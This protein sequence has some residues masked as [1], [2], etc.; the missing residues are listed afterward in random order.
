M[1]FLNLYLI[2]SFL[3]L[4][5]INITLCETEKKA[6]IRRELTANN[7]HPK[8][9]INFKEPILPTGW[10]EN[11]KEA[12]AKQAAK[13]AGTMG[14]ATRRANGRLLFAAKN[15]DVVKAKLALAD[16]AKPNF[17]D[18]GNYGYTPLGGAAST[19]CL[20]LVELLLNCGANINAQNHACITALMQAAGNNHIEVVRLLLNRGADVNLA[21]YTGRTALSM[22]ILN[23]NTKMVCLLLDHGAKVNTTIRSHRNFK[24]H[25]NPYTGIVTIYP[26]GSEIQNLEPYFEGMYKFDEATSTPLLQAIECGHAEVVLRLILAGATVPSESKYAVQILFASNPNLFENLANSNSYAAEYNAKIELLLSLGINFPAIQA[27]ILAIH[28]EPMYY[29]IR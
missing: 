18:W 27:N 3:V 15:G 20:E 11:T 6:E 16:G 9:H 8:Q 12:I 5:G 28:P 22:A 10:W 4:G 14:I 13:M 17:A 26:A 2:S 23:G 1:R 29:V 25:I 7:P 21:S 19:G 24:R